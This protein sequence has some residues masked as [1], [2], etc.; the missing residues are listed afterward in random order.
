M[1]DHDVTRPKE[2][3]RNIPPIAI[4]ETS[5]LVNPTGSWKYIMPRYEDRV[6]P[7]NAG[8]PVGI[9][10]EG[11]M[12]LIS[13]GRVKE[14]ANLLIREN[15]MPAVTGRVC[16]H[17]C[18]HS[19]NRASLDEPVAI[20]SVERRLGDMILAAPPIPAPE[21][22]R[23]ETV[24]VV[25]SGPA[26]LACAH[27]LARLGYGVSVFEAA[28][29]AGGMLRLGIP[30]YRLPRAILDRQIE[31]IAGAGIEIRTSTRI[32]VDIPWS[33]LDVFDAVFV[34]PGA[35][36]GKDSRIAGA[37]GNE[38]V[39]PGLEFLK[40]VN[41]GARPD[42]GSRVIVVGGGNTAMDCARSALRLGADVT[43]L[44]RRTPREMPAIPLEV[45]E[46][47]D[48]GVGFEFLAAP[49]AVVM[50]DGRFTG[51]TCQRME[52]GEPD[53]SGRRRPVPIEGDVFFAPADT[54]LTAI[55]EDCDLSFLPESV[56]TKWG[57]IE[58]DPVGESTS[59]PVFAGGDAVDMPRSVADALGAGKRAAIGIDHYLREKAG[60]AVGELPL[61]AL[62]FG[63]GNVSAV[64]YLEDGDPIPREAPVN[65]VVTW[66]RM[67]PHHFHLA[68]RHEDHFHDATDLRAAFGETNF[69]LSE[70]EAI[71]EAERCLNCGVCNRCELCLIFCPDMAISRREDGG[72]EIDMRYC[73]GCGLCA[74]ECPRGAVTMTREG[75]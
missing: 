38:A 73:K 13:Q 36:T 72:F 55:G 75:I 27:F 69:G 17:P 63:D 22:T 6:A 67:N 33:D 2:I 58:V 29:E 56:R 10:I 48:E 42:L 45:R 49:M 21:R 24:A 64:R 32:G 1:S 28:S 11:Y 18:E 25:G 14:A 68:P 71:E 65:E 61:G 39:R 59:T 15:P 60:E 34:A 50:E 30:E 23:R 8:C 40:E 46:A 74:A 57:L 35:H 70:K 5:T 51:I 3:G 20:H 53:E 52:L 12:Y 26:G 66:D 47:R 31:R 16:H 37:E 44:Y 7:C 19:C 62:R 54:V 4:S 9:D 43:V 41:A